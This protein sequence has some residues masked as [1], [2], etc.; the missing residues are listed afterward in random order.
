MRQTASA[1]VR[2]E[3]RL[4]IKFLVDQAGDLTRQIV[5]TKPV[6]DPQPFR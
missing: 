1:S 4:Q 6:V 3:Q 2:R 5:L